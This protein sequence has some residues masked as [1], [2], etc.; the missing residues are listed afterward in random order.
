MCGKGE[1]VVNDV[2]FSVDVYGFV[3]RK[4]RHGAHRLCTFCCA[5]A[6]TSSRHLAYACVRWCVC[7]ICARKRK[8]DFPV[9]ACTKKDLYILVN[10]L[11]RIPSV[12]PMRLLA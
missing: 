11:N 1:R 3:G 10:R 9:G 2:C 4:S 6:V 5:Y 8:Y 7:V 12:V